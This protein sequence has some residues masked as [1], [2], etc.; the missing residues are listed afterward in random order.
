MLPDPVQSLLFWYAN[1]HFDIPVAD[2]DGSM[3]VLWRR[4][5]EIVHGNG[6]PARASKAK[7][8]F[9]GGP[10]WRNL[11]AWLRQCHGDK[12]VPCGL[13]AQS[14]RCEPWKEFEEVMER[15]RYIVEPYEPR[16]RDDVDAVA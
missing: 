16:W 9:A 4:H 10:N 3:D 12:S 15:L 8:T 5:C 2:C 13:G 7:L 6:I 1:C 11:M 14:G